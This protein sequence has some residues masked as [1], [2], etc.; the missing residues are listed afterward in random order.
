MPFVQRV[1]QPVNVA[2]ATAAS[3]GQAATRFQCSPG[4]CT[5]N[6]CINKQTNNDVVANNDE[7]DASM[8]RALVHNVTN[9]DADDE[10]R[11]PAALPMKKLKQHVEFLPS[12]SSA[13][14]VSASTSPTRTSQSLPN[15]R[16]AS[17]QRAGKLNGHSSLSAPHSP[18][19]SGATTRVIS[20]YEFDSISNITLSNA[21]RQLASLVLIASDIFDDLQR[22]LQSVGERAGRVQRKILAVERRVCAYDPK[23]VTVPE[24]D[25]LT[26]AQR[27]QHFDSD[28]S[29][30]QE[31]FT[32]DSRPHSVRQLYKDAGKQLLLM[33]M[34]PTTPLRSVSF[35]GDVGVVNGDDVLDGSGEAEEQLLCS[36]LDFGNANRK[37]RTRIDAEIEIRLPAAIEDLRKWTS[38]EALGDVTVTPDCMHHVDTSI[39]TS[40]V[41]GDNGILTPALSPS[42]LSADAL[43]A[44][45]AIN[46]SQAA[47]SSSHHH[48]HHH[49]H[50]HQQQL[51]LPN[52][53]NKDVPLNHRLPSPEEQTKI[54]A[55]KYPA[56]VI[57]VNTSGKHFQ[58]M[59]AARKSTTG[60]YAGG[61]GSTANGA[62][63][64]PST[65]GGSPEDNQ[66]EANNLDDNV[67]TVSRRS[68]S[69]KVRGKRRNTIAGIDQKEIQDAANGVSTFL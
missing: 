44:Q 51:L 46:I 32:Q 34:A 5:N 61:A 13:A 41:I 52:D 57:S 59:C 26:F 69:R 17:Q 64:T 6:N 22:D 28:K 49:N 2:Q 36:D 40:L 45:Y 23:M 48:H 19:A 42:V 62:V 65:S 66:S 8:T 14:S 11:P 53:I 39:C 3:L 35:N 25:L 58:R 18:T 68:R 1:V 20:G 10:P 33:P 55:L 63:S 47:D 12:T 38:S 15:S 67:Q 56:E 50:H 27:K 31:L 4:K 21:L 7:T 37:L 43:D 16:H 54:I 24:S 29:F 60:C 30:Q 9:C